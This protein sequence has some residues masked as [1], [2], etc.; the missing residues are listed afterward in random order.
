MLLCWATYCHPAYVDSHTYLG[1]DCRLSG[2]RYMTIKL[3]AF[4]TAVSLGIA[5]VPVSR[6][7]RVYVAE[8][9]GIQRR[10]VWDPDL[11][12]HNPVRLV[13]RSHIGELLA[14]PI[15]NHRGLLTIN[16]LNTRVGQAHFSMTLA[17][18]RGQNSAGHQA[19]AA[20]RLF[21]PSPEGC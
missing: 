17:V 16:A 19:R 9:D 7:A 2:G 8:T 12:K 5:C 13:R 14:I 1:K 4:F 20:R 6:T 3:L 11:K 15:V 18:H 21:A 10:L